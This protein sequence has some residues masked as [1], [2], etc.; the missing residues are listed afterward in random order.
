MIIRIIRKTKN[1]L[2]GHRPV[3][4]IPQSRCI[5]ANAV[6]AKDLKDRDQ[7]EQDSPKG[8]KTSGLLNIVFPLHI[9]EV[10]EDSAIDV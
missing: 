5:N 2:N 1:C 7:R 3:C 4:R 8:V 9:A 6:L 10:C